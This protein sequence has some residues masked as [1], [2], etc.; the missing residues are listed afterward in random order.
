MTQAISRTAG[1]L[2]DY[3][4]GLTAS[5]VKA[6]KGV[7][8]ENHLI[9]FKTLQLPDFT[10]KSDKQNLACS[11]SAFSNSE[12]GV[13]IWGVQA[14]RDKNDSYVDQVTE[15]AGVLNPKLVL[16]R[17]MELT[18]QACSPFPIGIQH[19]IIKGK[20]ASFV[21]TY[22]P[23]SDGGPH[24]A[25]LGMGKYYV[26]SGG[27]SLPMEHFQIADMFGRRAAPKPTVEAVNIS[28]FEFSLRVGNNGRGAAH[29]PFL[30]VEL[31]PPFRPDIFSQPIWP[32]SSK[33]R[34]CLFAANSSVVIHPTMDVTVMRFSINQNP[35]HA[36][37]AAAAHC[38]IRYKIGAVGIAPIEGELKLRLG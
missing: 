30:Q 32:A 37:I 5:K 12:G 31:S 11:L 14:T 34:V 2:L 27:S 29:A 36:D 33:G 15:V 17:L 10:H 24:M 1:S 3:F 25:Q 8:Q 26:R 20:T 16:S 23:A 6:M 13:I 18:S 28:G 21:A 38:L 19:R 22:V 35:S 4:E 7:A 9:E